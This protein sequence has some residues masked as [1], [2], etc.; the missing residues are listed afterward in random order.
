MQHT[1]F[2]KRAAVLATAA[3]VV[4]VPL[5]APAHASGTTL[6]GGYSKD[7]AYWDSAVGAVQIYRGYDLGFTAQTWTAT[8]AYK[9]HPNA[10]AYDYSFNL[11]PAEIIT[12]AD[13]AALTAFI[14][15]T[16]RNTVM[17]NYHEPEPKIEAGWAT[18]QDFRAAEAH[19]ASLVHTQNG[20]DSGSRKVSLVLM[21]STFTGYKGRNPATYWPTPADCQALPPATSGS[22][23]ML[24][25]VSTDAYALPHNTGTTG[26]PIGYTDGLRWKTATM[27]LGPVYTWAVA[28]N[29]P[30]AVSEL[31]Y[32]EDIT[33]PT[34][35][36]TELTNVVA[37][38]RARGALFVEYWDAKGGRADWEL[39]Y[40]NPVPSTSTTSNAIQAWK[41]AANGS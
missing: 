38:A 19:L 29:T 11:S 25:L 33:D 6:I 30:W 5:A 17:T 8:T 21:V 2:A 27:L 32:L 36:A 12:G 14:A 24:D 10:G 35:K 4:V 15:S 22:C 34:H 41:A 20:I 13:D 18:A 16:P 7:W 1:T 31:G 26:V 3:V 23:D 40:S 9:A 28:N 37:Y 39:K